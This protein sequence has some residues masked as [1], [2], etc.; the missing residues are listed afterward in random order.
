MDLK[1]FIKEA[2]AFF[3]VRRHKCREGG[4]DIPTGDWFNLGRGFYGE[5]WAHEDSEYVLKISGPAGWGRRHY[6]GTHT[7]VLDAMEYYVESTPRPDAWPVFARHCMAHPHKHL[8]TVHHVVQHNERMAWAVMKQYKD[9]NGITGSDLYH[10]FK[11]VLAGKRSA[12]AMPWMWP[13]RQM[14][15]GLH[16]AVDLHTGNVM[17][18]ADEGCLVITDP[19]STTGTDSGA[20]NFYT[21]RPT[22]ATT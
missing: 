17:W 14:T 21:D 3:A 19:F 1:A 18:D 11:A 5:A 10:E 15:D 16:F 12:A 13:L 22:S 8:P 2:E 20:G 6:S 4:D 9:W 7:D